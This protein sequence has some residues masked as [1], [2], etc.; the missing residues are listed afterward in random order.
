MSEKP[1]NQRDLINYRF[2]EVFKRLDRMEGK[3]DSFAYTPIKE[4]EEFKR[5]VKE[6]YAT[7]MFVTP[8]VRITY[9][10]IGLMAAA[11]LGAIMSGVL[12]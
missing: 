8:S 6:T 4:F 9:G 1:S 3:M 11:V 2:D 7:K 12:K 5:E 10:L